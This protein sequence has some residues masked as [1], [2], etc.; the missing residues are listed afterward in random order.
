MFSSL[1]AE[2]RFAAFAWFAF[3]GLGFIAWNVTYGVMSSQARQAAYAER[4]NQPS[5]HQL[6]KWLDDAIERGLIHP[7]ETAPRL[8]DDQIE[9][10]K[11]KQQQVE[12]LLR[13]LESMGI[14]NPEQRLIEARIAAAQEK[15]DRHPMSLVSLYDTLVRLQRWVF[16]LE[17]QWSAIVPSMVTTI[18]ITFF[19][20]I[21]LVRNVSA[22]T[23]V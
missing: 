13:K 22:S 10:L 23:R 5:A 19:A 16:G 4:D 18:S 2:S 7:S 3:W 15:I 12:K 6:E 17:T 11:S 9:V 8:S 1:T 20:W 14:E 21:V